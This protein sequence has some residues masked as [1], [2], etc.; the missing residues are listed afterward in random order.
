MFG[1]HPKK[2]LKTKPKKNPENCRKNMSK[3]K[4]W[5]CKL[6]S[7]QDIFF[8]SY[9]CCYVL[10]KLQLTGGLQT[11]H[12]IK[13]TAVVHCGS[14]KSLLRELNRAVNVE[15]VWKPLCTWTLPAHPWVTV[16]QKFQM[17]NC[18]FGRMLEPYRNQV[19]FCFMIPETS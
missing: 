10:H 18:S 17:W 9:W 14:D 19:F 5:Y 4:Q 2:T 13:C 3:R 12:Y 1:N 8:C 15:S 7:V 16:S 11:V 6:A